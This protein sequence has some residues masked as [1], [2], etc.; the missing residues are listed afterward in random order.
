MGR[1]PVKG[2]HRMKTRRHALTALA[3]SSPDIVGS[4]AFAPSDS[5]SSS[6][7]ITVRYH[8]D[9]GYHMPPTVHM[10]HGLIVWIR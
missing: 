8:S 9:T 1:H 4:E 10:V 6:T 5:D 3:L 2:L 7:M